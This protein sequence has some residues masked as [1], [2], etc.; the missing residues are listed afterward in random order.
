MSIYRLITFAFASLLLIIGILGFLPPVTPNNMFLGIFQVDHMH[1]TFHIVSG[2][3]GVMAAFA[4]NL[5]SKVFHKIFSV[6]YGLML[7]M[8]FTTG[9]A[10]GFG[11]VGVNPASNLLHLAFTIIGSYMGFV[12]NVI[13]SETK[14]KATRSRIRYAH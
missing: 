10:L 4:G 2:L 5:S 14:S 9:F 11:I 8:G 7:V 12:M 3:F 6:M 13:F 1:N